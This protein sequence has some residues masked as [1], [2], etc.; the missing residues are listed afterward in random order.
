MNKI[1]ESHKFFLGRK[2]PTADFILVRA[3]GGG[4][5]F[6]TNLIST[7]HSYLHIWLITLKNQGEKS[8]EWGKELFLA[9]K[10]ND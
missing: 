10:K 1:L 8:I 5:V 2:I 3:V 9:F 6:Q 7:Y 4:R